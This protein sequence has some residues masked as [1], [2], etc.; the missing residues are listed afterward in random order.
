MNITY[1][2]YDRMQERLEKIPNP[3]VTW[4]P[5]EDDLN[6]HVIKDPEKYLQFLFWLTIT[7]SPV[8]DEDKSNLRAVNRILYEKIIFVD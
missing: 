8:S 3:S 2:E 4:L 7:T 5:T 1:E 6:N